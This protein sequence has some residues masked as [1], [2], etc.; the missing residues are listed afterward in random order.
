M[1]ASSKIDSSMKISKRKSTPLQASM[2]TKKKF[3]DDTT[4]KSIESDIIVSKME[5][6]DENSVSGK[7]GQGPPFSQNK[8]QTFSPQSI[9]PFN[10]M[11]E[12]IDKNLGKLHPAAVG[13]KL[14]QNNIIGVIET[15]FVGK[16]RIKVEFNDHHYANS[17]I[18][19]PILQKENWKA[20]IPSHILYRKGVIRNVPNIFTDDIIREEFKED[21]ELCERIDDFY[22]IKRNTSEGQIVTGTIV[23][24]FKGQLLPE[25]I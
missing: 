15:S 25:Y 24:T 4:N 9:G 17:F 5:L 22:R 3:T 12:S 14:K 7:T 19:H 23:I 1:S 21:I 20:Y 13:Y 16:N 10:V 8:R 11:V 6:S 2:A 18:T